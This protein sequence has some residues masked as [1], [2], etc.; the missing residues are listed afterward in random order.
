MA[1][2]QDVVIEQKDWMARSTLKFFERQKG[3]VMVRR[4][5]ELGSDLA[6]KVLTKTWEP[7]SRDAHYITK[8]SRAILADRVSQKIFQED[9]IF[10]AETTINA[11]FTRISDYLERRIEQANQKLIG[12]GE[13]PAAIIFPTQRYAAM[14]STRVATDWLNLLAKADVYLRL[15]EYLWIAGELSDVQNEALR[16]KL[17]N[18]RDVRNNLHALPRKTMS[19]FTIIRRI[20]SGV[21]EQRMGEREK[22]SQRD[23]ALALAAKQGELDASQ[24]EMDALAVGANA[25][26]AAVEA[27][28]AA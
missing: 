19:Q 6:V 28:A 2:N 15:H 8:Q 18:E 12:A 5:V 24:A 10:K 13:D 27:P 11:E 17:N 25:S 26:G 23:K 3:A 20:C 14:C 9:E 1:T 21:I 22:Q 16:A 7:V 4:V